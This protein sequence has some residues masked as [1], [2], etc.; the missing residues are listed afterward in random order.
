MFELL[1]RLLRRLFRPRVRV[2]FIVGPPQK[3]ITLLEITTIQKQ[4]VD[5]QFPNSVGNPVP[6]DGVPSWSIEDEAIATLEVDPTGLGGFVVAG[7]PGTTRLTV[8]ADAKLG[9]GIVEISGLLEINVTEDLAV[10]VDFILGE[11]RN[12]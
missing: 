2:A 10:R 4:R 6:I 8:T 3:E 11:I 12:K 1:L 9:D 5:L 7:A